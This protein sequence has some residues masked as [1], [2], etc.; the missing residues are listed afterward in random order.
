MGGA[1]RK[2][3]APSCVH[4][5]HYEHG[6]YWLYHPAHQPESYEAPRRFLH[7]RLLCRSRHLSIGCTHPAIN[8][9]GQTKRA[10]AGA[11]QV[12][13]GNFGAILGT[14]LYRPKTAPRYLLGHSFALGYLCM[15]LV[16]VF[17]LWCVLRR[18]NKKKQEYLASHPETNGI[19]DTEEDLKLGDRHPRWK[20]NV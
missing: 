10:V 18:D 6:N 11:L 5:D 9:S 2:I 17:T 16:V 13:V 14:Q 19:H 12:T 8:V 4:H 1:V 15:N 7:G 20:F 3:P